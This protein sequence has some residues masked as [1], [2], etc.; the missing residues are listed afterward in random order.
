MT[1][2]RQENLPLEAK[3]S[4]WKLF[5]RLRA[6]LREGVICTSEYW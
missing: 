4:Q 1:I 6:K 3:E 5:C 2:M